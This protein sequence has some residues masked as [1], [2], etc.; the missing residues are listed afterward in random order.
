MKNLI[1]AVDT[2]GTNVRIAAVDTAKG[3]IIR[4][5]FPDSVDGIVRRGMRS[6]RSNEEIAD[7]IAQYVPAGSGIGISLTGDVD[8][9][10]L[11]S[12]KAPNSH[13]KGAIDFPF[14]LKKMGYDVV[15]TNDLRAA[16]QA[17]AKYG[18][19]RGFENVGT[20]TY[21]SGFDGA[22]V[23]K[24]ENTTFA[25]IG[26]MLYDLKSILFCGCSGQGHLELYVSAR[27]GAAMAQFYFLM[28]QEKDHPILRNA[29]VSY[30][31]RAAERFEGQFSVRDMKNNDDVRGNV[32]FAITAK[33]VYDA[34]K[35]DPEMEPQKT[36]QATQ[37]EAIAHSFGV[38]VSAYNPLDIIVCMGSL[39]TNNPHEIFEPARELYLRDTGRFQLNTLRVPE[40]VITR[41][42]EIGVQGAAAY[43]LS[44]RKGSGLG[45]K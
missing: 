26:H 15:V 1:Y 12:K 25:E 4:Q 44:Q 45:G 23:R 38:M 7:F 9:E 22:V 6:F 39:V 37:K 11:L 40:V 42:P 21:S 16:C 10:R 17:S 8:E 3:R 33:E 29:L 41:L 20:V 27:G 43:Y 13:I 31:K 19:G 18:E 5:A 24:G 32:I 35:A 28:T 34:F 14:R 36:I 2:G 30:N